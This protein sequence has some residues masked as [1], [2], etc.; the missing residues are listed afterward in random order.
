MKVLLIGAG[1]VSSVMSKVLAK[2]SKVSE[3]VCCARNIEKAKD[4]IDIKNDKI[5]LKRLDAS[6]INDIVKLAKGKDIIINASVPKLNRTIM[7]AALKAGVNYQ[8][9][10]S[11]LVDYKT[12]DQ[13]RFHKKFQ[14]KGLVGLIN[15]GIS[16]GVTNL[17]IRDAADKLDRVEEIKIRL[18]EE[19]KANEL[20]FAWSPEVTLDEVTSPALVYKNKKVVLCKPFADPEEYEF[21]KPFGKKTVVGIQGDEVATVPLY[22]KTNYMDYKSGGTDIDLAKSLYR[23]GL[24]SKVPIKLNGN[25]IIPLEFF[26]RIAPRVPTPKE[27]IRLIKNK[28]VE[29]AMYTSVIEITGKESGKNIK[30]KTTALFPDLKKISKIFPGATYISYPTGLSAAV[31]TKIIPKMGTPGVYPP[32]ALNENIRKEILIELED[33]GITIQKEYS[34]V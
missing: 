11:Y 24:F 20:I 33:S 1:G 12:P 31:F 6:N 22:I 4:F 32:E 27:M 13:L 17:L 5:E 9:L 28:V 21:Q 16:P 15:T 25:K 10:C 29:N 34:K 30:V 18:V 7:A 14:K 23:L 26:S 2:S 8:D 19:Q 3:V